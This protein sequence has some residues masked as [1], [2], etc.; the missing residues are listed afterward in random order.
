MGVL[1][2]RVQKRG[3]E[4]KGWVID[5]LKEKSKKYAQKKLFSSKLKD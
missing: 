1:G 5:V 2:K 4:G 3:C